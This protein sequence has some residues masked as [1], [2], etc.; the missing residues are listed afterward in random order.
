MH[1]SET[2]YEGKPL[3]RLL[4]CYVLAK[5]ECLSQKDE[6]ALIALGPKLRTLYNVAG[7]WQHVIECVMHLPPDIPAQIRNLWVK[8]TEIART[9]GVTLEPQQ[10]AEM[11]VDQNLVS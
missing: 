7:N 1:L 6:K 9:N 3:L 2:R 11:F 8:N 4:E 10:F 5:I